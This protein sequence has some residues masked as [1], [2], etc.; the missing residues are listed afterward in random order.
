MGIQK[1]TKC[2]ELDF[3]IP[4]FFLVQFLV[5]EMWSIL[6]STVAYSELGNFEKSGKDFCKSDTNA[7]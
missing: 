7:S 3:S 4:E 1:D 5:F 6:Y 2:S